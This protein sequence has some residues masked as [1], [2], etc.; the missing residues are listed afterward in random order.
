MTEGEFPF[1]TFTM[2]SEGYDCEEVDGYM[3]E[4]R[5]EVAELRRALDAATLAG[6]GVADARL[7]DPEGAVTRTLAI[8]Q[9]TADRVLHDAQIEA[10]RRRA[11]A[12]EQ[13]AATIS[14]ANERAA[15]MMADTETQTAE[16]RAQGIAAARS[17]IQVERDQ[18][19]AE[20]GQIRRVRDDIRNEAVELKSVLERY[21]GQARDASDSLAATASGA[22]LTF[23]LPDFVADDVALAGVVDA[24]ELGDPAPVAAVAAP[25]AAAPA[26]AAPVAPAPPPADWSPATQPPPAEIAQPAPI[27]AP[28][29]DSQPTWSTGAEDVGSV[30]A[31]SSDGLADVIAIDGDPVV[32]ASAEVADSAAGGGTFLAEVQAAADEDLI[33]LDAEHVGES[34]RFLSELRGA[35]D[36][37][38][39][40]AGDIFFDND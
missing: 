7:H 30:A 2:R 35:T 33:D 12:D 18:A 4:L 31:S 13:A 5:S 25:P 21:A 28:V 39:D 29:S 16:V 34:D 26:A 8:A 36:G 38:E 32:A 27:G 1:R 19:I 22:L 20:L 10:D 40:G 37:P 14:D 3:S 15:K 24:G 17:A 6:S 23:D 9:E 11:E